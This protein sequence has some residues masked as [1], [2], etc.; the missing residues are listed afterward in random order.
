M[1]YGYNTDTPEIPSITLCSIC[2]SKLH[3]YLVSGAKV[4]KHFLQDSIFIILREYSPSFLFQCLDPVYDGL[5]VIF[6]I[7]C[8]VSADFKYIE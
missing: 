6:L 3:V 1:F 8:C 5:T 7:S 4:V 2:S